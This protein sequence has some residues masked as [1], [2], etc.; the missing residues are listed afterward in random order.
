[1]CDVEICGRK[2]LHIVNMNV[3][4]GER[5]PGRNMKRSAHPVYFE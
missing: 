5:F 1:M 3:I 4:D 2:G